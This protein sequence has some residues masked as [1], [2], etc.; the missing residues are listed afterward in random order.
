MTHHR[1]ERLL[2]DGRLEELEPDPEDVIGLWGKAVENWEAYRAGELPTATAFN[3][4]YTAGFQ[5]ATAVL[6][7][8]GYRARGGAGAG[9]HWSTFYA[10]RGLEHARIDALA[11][12]LNGARSLRHDAIYDPTE[13]VPAEEMEDLVGAVDALFGVAQTYLYDRLPELEGD[14][15]LP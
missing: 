4:V 10:L 2:G 9:H 8:D 15:T 7:A 11:V 12:T 5:L 13:Q 1:L 14:L 3:V 6:R